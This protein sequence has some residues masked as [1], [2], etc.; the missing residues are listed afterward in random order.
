[1]PYLNYVFCEECG[2]PHALDIDQKGTID[3]YIKERRADNFINPATLVWDYLFYRCFKCH[4]SFKYTYRDIEMLVREYFSNMS[5]AYK[6]RFDEIVEG[7]D[8]VHR[9]DTSSKTLLRIEERYRD[10][11]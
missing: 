4:K 6:I 11:K 5:E 8:G 1:M 2:P 9:V 10:R 7:K 3:A